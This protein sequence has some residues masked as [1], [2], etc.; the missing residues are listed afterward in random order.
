METSVSEYGRP[1]KRGKERERERNR[2]GSSKEVKGGR[3]GR[4]RAKGGREL[5]KGGK[6]GERREE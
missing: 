6:K 4:I 3:G 2:E 5:R 1:L